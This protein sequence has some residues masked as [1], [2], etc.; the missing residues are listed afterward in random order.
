MRP[1]PGLC[2]ILSGN[3]LGKIKDVVRE[4]EPRLHVIL[5]GTRKG[6][7]QELL[8]SN[9]MNHLLLAVRENYD[10]VILDTPPV[11][12]VADALVLARHADATL[13]VVRW[14]KTARGAVRDAVRLLQDSRAQILGAVMTR[15][16]LRTASRSGGR[17]AY[18]FTRYDGYHVART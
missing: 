18:A 15:V 7:P 5:A 14:E 16:D 10:L 17:M 3:L 13:M 8:A 11:L 12:P 2:D 6:D 4:P 1:G 9:R